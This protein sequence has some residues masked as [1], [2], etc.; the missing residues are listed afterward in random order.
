MREV[1]HQVY[2]RDEKDYAIEEMP[3]RQIVRITVVNGEFDTT[4]VYL[5]MAVWNAMAYTW[6]VRDKQN[7]DRPEPER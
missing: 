3:E 7:L 2:L 6:V 1:F 4:D 5:P